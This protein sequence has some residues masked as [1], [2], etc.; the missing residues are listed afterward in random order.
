MDEN[1]NKI[2]ISG[3]LHDIGKFAEMGCMDINPEFLNNHT[4]LYQPFFDGRHTHKHAV[5][6]AAFID[7]IEKFLPHE[8][9]RGNWGSIDDFMNLAAGHHKPETPFQWII[10]I[11]DRVSSGFDRDEF[12]DY[13]K[14]IKVQD[15]KKTR[16]L[17]IFEGISTDGKWKEDNLNAYLYRYPLKELSPENIFPVDREDYR[18]LDSTRAS[19]EYKDLF[20]NFVG[21]LEFLEHKKNVPLWFEHFDSLFMIYASHIPAA[22]VGNV[23]PDVSL[24]DHSKTTA[25]LASAVY[26][27]H[28]Q[29]NSM[30]VENIKDYADKKFLIVNGDFYGIQNFIFTEGGSTNK[31]AAKLLRGRSFAVSLITELAADMLCREIGLTTCSIITNAAGKFS[32]IAPNTKQTNDAIKT[33]QEKI[34]DW[35]I[36][37]FYGETSFGI[38]LIDASS[39]D[40]VSK[41][42]DSLWDR[43]TEDSEKKKYN[44]INLDKYGGVIGNYLDQ[45][46]NDLS[47]KLCPFCGKRP[48]SAEVENDQLIKDESACKVCRDH[49]YLGTNIVKTDKIAITTIDAEIYGKKLCEPIFSEYQVSLDVDGKLM[50][51]SD[52]GTLLK[53]WDISISQDGNLSKKITAKFIN[54]YVPKYSKDDEED[55]S[56]NRLLY[57]EKSE[58]KKEEL[59]DMLNDKVPKSFHHI[60]K[61]ALNST[62]VPDK[63][64]GIE[65]LGVL[66]ADVDNLGLIFACGLKRNSLSR[67]ATLSR[68]MNHFFTIYLPNTLSTKEDFENIYTV[69]AGG[70]DLFLIG[71][72]NKI[73]DFAMFLDE[74][75]QKYV[76]GNNKITLSAG[77]SINKPGEPVLSIGERSET[78]LKKSKGNGR[79]SIT[80]FDESVKWRDY[81]DLNKIKETIESWMDSKTINNAMLYR[82]NTFSSLAEQEKELLTIKDGVDMEE[83]ECLKWGAMFKYTLIRNVGKNLKGDEKD[84]ALSEVEKAAGW[85]AQYGGTMKIPLWQVI[86]NQR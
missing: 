20:L 52:K 37:M 82:L 19:E 54:G 15:Y 56:L 39:D 80:I 75:F 25:A 5:Y 30:E 23:V 68:Q 6:T 45:F 63:F 74:F 7:H 42:F 18:L 73:I 29:N 46:N 4:D 62:D 11:A 57:G 85:L 81:E 26:L 48:S 64:A 13:N 79:N 53:Y 31:A 1:I 71:P 65:A 17:T 70:D 3:F 83:C 49:I 58:K 22:T 32:I 47:K 36:R 69:F 55:E 33:I 38:S 40:F 59:F 50:Q 24:Y 86:Y 66:K 77:I 28:L 78:S 2:A 21:A 35:L 14:E 72:W 41:R 51:L 27:Y 8:F 67:L 60:A 34:N 16:L 12:E 61:W 43:I 76:C 9:N 44:K 10:A 84:R